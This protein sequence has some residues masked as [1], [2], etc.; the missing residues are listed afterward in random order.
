MAKDTAVKVKGT[1]KETAEKV[2]ELKEVA[3][4]KAVDIKNKVHKPAGHEDGEKTETVE[5][6]ETIET[7]EMQPENIDVIEHKVPED[8]ST[9]AEEVLQV[10]QGLREDSKAIENAI[11]SDSAIEEETVKKS[12]DTVEII[13]PDE[14]GN[15]EAA[16]VEKDFFSESEAVDQEFQRTMPVDII[17][18]NDF[19]A[20][21]PEIKPVQKNTPFTKAMKLRKI[22]TKKNTEE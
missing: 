13:T 12:D 14:N 9:A 10:G 5:T 1:A 19:E 22:M 21:E 7:I 6:I 18:E 11:F 3:A 4:V 20:D 2:N 15:E 16:D 17:S 8:V